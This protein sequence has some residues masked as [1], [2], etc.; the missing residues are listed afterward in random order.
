MK[1]QLP[2]IEDETAGI[3]DDEGEDIIKSINSLINQGKVS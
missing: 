1:Q 3:E 2:S